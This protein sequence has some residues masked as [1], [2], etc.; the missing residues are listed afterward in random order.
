MVEKLG[1]ISNPDRKAK[2]PCNPKGISKVNFIQQQVM[3]ESFSL[4]SP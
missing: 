1:W 2:S 4:Y 3:Y